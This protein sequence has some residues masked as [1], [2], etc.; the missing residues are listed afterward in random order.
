MS[1]ARRYALVTSLVLLLGGC[2]GGGGQHARSAAPAT[3]SRTS[4]PAV[5]YTPQH[6]EG[7]LLRAHDIGSTTRST[8]LTIL[9]LTEGSVPSCADTIVRLP[10]RP[11]TAATQFGPPDPRYTGENYAV[12]AAVYP[13]AASASE[14]FGRVRAAV[15]ACPGERHIGA[16]KIRHQQ[17][18]L[19]YDET[20][21]RTADTVQGWTHLR[22]FEKR[23]YSPDLSI[24]NIEYQ[25]YDYALRG[26]AVI[27]T[28][29]WKRGKPSMTPGPVTRQAST[30]LARQLTRIG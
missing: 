8:P 9:G 16:K 21:T 12:L 6:V 1:H 26:N 27:S 20:W 30:L 22:G 2:G 7:A 13:D 28:L 3:A 14:A 29:Y 4:T 18:T 15:T 23:T 25:A 10:G 19:A 24:I 11:G 17:T 5:T